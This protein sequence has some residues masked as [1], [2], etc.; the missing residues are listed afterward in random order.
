MLQSK[1]S[2]TVCTSP[3]LASEIPLIALSVTDASAAYALNLLTSSYE[4][5]TPM[6]FRGLMRYF[7]RT[8]K[9]RAICESIV[10][11][12]IMLVIML[13]MRSE[14]GVLSSLKVMWER[15]YIKMGL[16]TCETEYLLMR[17][18][19]ELHFSRNAS[20]SLRT[21]FASLSMVMLSS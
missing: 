12:V 21:L 13:Q 14:G 19:Y 18:E 10:V 4:H 2:I 3:M 16:L 5:V 17:V 15:N 6:T 9:P 7:S 1:L 11:F 20:D 8:S